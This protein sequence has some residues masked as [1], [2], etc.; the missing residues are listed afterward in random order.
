MISYKVEDLS[1]NGQVIDDH[2]T[3]QFGEIA[4]ISYLVDSLI[5]NVEKREIEKAVKNYISW[6][7]KLT[8]STPVYGNVATATELEYD[9]F[10]IGNFY[11]FCKENKDQYPFVKK[12]RT[13]ELDEIVIGMWLKNH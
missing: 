7:A 8:S 5:D 2:M 3:N 11:N 6:T 10:N 1:V 13:A 9:V 4:A 12:E